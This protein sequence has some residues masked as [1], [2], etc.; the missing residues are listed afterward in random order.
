M[1]LTVLL[2]NDFCLMK[3]AILRREHI[4]FF[5]SLAKYLLVLNNEIRVKLL[6]HSCGTVGW[7]AWYRITKNSRPREDNMLLMS[8]LWGMYTELS[9]CSKSAVSN[10]V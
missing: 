2:S 3:A 1:S 10:R 6:S 8:V 5:V 9:V 7:L 4:I